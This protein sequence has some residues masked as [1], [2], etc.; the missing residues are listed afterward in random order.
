MLFGY[1]FSGLT[2]YSLD[3]FMLG[4]LDEMIQ[5]LQIALQNKLLENIDE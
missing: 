1:S 3:R 5:G 2:L 4:D